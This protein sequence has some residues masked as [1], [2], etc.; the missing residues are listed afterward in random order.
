[1]KLKGL[2]GVE[3]RSDRFKKERAG[4]ERINGLEKGAFNP[5]TRERRRLHVEHQRKTR[6]AWDAETKMEEDR[7]AKWGR[8]NINRTDKSQTPKTDGDG[9]KLKDQS[10]RPM[11]RW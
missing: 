9:W 6:E 7:W 2:K 1:M 4:R 8:T 10:G 3:D 5:K 11:K